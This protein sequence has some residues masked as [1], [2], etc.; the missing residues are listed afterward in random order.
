MRPGHIGLS[1]LRGWLVKM[2]DVTDLSLDAL[3]IGLPAVTSAFGASL[4]EAAAVCL[5]AQGQ[6]SRI[7]AR[8]KEKV[9][10]TQKYGSRL[11]AYVIVIEFGQPQA[12]MVQR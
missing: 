3:V 4:A 5:D 11:P 9:Q 6:E 8:V 2:A 1:A 7:R 10:Q 12:R